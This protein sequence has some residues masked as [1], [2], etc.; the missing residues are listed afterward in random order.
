MDIFGVSYIQSKVFFSNFIGYSPAVSYT[1]I[2]VTY[3]QTMVQD[4][5]DSL[6]EGQGQ[7]KL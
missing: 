6:S 4:V 5:C 2:D 7:G 3:T 1:Y